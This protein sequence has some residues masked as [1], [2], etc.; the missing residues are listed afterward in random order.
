MLSPS[1]L[2]SY[3]CQLIHTQIH[4]SDSNGVQ[5]SVYEDHGEQPDLFVCDPKFLQTLLPLCSQ[6]CPRLFLEMEHF[7]YGLITDGSD[8]YIIGPCSVGGSSPSTIRY[9]MKEH[10]LNEENEY[11]IPP[12]FLSNLVHMMRMLH[13]S[14]NGFDVTVEEVFR[15]SFCD[16]CFEQ[17]LRKKEYQVL[18][19]LR[20]AETVHN[21][22][23]QELLEMDAV[24]S[25]DLEALHKS[26]TIAYVGKVGT[27]ARDELR[28][29]KNMTIVLVSIAC[30]AAIEGGLLPEVAFS[31]SDTYIQ[32]AEEMHT[33]G[34][35]FALAAQAEIEY[36]RAVHELKRQ[37]LQS[38][39]VIRC[40]TLVSKK[41]YSRL[42]VSDI[43]DAM[44]LNP[45]YLSQVFAREEGMRLSEYILQQK[46]RAAK[47]QLAYTNM[48]Y[49]QI[50][51]TLGFSSQ[52]H[53]NTMFKKQ[54]GITPKQFRD[55]LYANRL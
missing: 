27:L 33:G 8:I 4:V 37:K 50:A 36:C 28:Q 55:E 45:N 15:G 35:V 48:P 31:M 9:W 10:S 17:E 32:R 51:V 2:C 34:E 22:Y 19:S 25:G 11:R 5:I 54:T 16:E 13:A 53:F 21:P 6:K 29:L 49:S 46:I 44:G 3:I 30:R 23:S 43:A 20:E 1:Q 12:V 39:T 26:H 40:K 52:S 24:R 47:D 7:A 42:T 18:H 41:L 14:L 38:S